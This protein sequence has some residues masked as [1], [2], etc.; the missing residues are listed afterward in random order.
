MVYLG[1]DADSIGERAAARSDGYQFAARRLTNNTAPLRVRRGILR[2]GLA[3]V[4]DIIG[5]LIA[6][7][8]AWA[9]A[10]Q[11]GGE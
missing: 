9:V 10:F 7:G 3:M 6:V 1:G 11:I 8:F 4:Q 2:E 5:C